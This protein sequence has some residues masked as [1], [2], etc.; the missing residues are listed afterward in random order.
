MAWQQARHQQPCVPHAGKTLSMTAERRLAH[1]SSALRAHT[2]R[3]PTPRRSQR[4]A[5]ACRSQR[6]N[7]QASGETRHTRAS[8]ELHRQGSR[9]R[10]RQRHSRQDKQIATRR[11]PVKHMQEMQDVGVRHSPQVAIGGISA[12]DPTSTVRT[13]PASLG[14]KVGTG[15]PPVFG[16]DGVHRESVT[17]VHARSRLANR[18][19]QPEGLH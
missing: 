11:A 12:G 13:E 2:L 4:R 15:Q 8:G 6:A 1:G 19:D 3:D 10:R 9:G 16:D 14:H 18:T 17:A 7:S 5:A